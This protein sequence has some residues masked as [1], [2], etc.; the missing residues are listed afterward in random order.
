[1][2]RLHVLL[3]KHLLKLKP[4]GGAKV[5]STPLGG[6]TMHCILSYLGA[7]GDA[8]HGLR[9]SAISRSANVKFQMKTLVFKIT[10]WLQ[11]HPHPIKWPWQLELC[12][13]M[14]R[15]KGWE[16]REKLCRSPALWN[17]FSIALLNIKKTQCDIR[18]VSI[19][20]LLVWG[21]LTCS[22]LIHLRLGFQ[23][24]F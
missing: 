11:D 24:C 19:F 5:Y 16:G 18:R 14:L 13:H 6:I 22:S 3:S 12:S 9:V 21:C 20:Q 1:M 4:H 17:H 2:T 23:C 15:Q 8:S 10:A 7:S